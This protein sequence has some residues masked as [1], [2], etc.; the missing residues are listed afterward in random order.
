MYPNRE[1]EREKVIVIITKMFCK[2]SKEDSENGEDSSKA[3]K[4]HE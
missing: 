2:E 1:R 4:R 3:F